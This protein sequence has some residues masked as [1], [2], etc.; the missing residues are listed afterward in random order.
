[1]SSKFS[2]R[3]ALSVLSGFLLFA[4]FP[5]LNWHWFVWVATLPLLL[6]LVCERSL[7]RA[8]LLGYISGFIFLGGSCYWFVYVMR[9][10]GGMGWLL[11]IGVLVLFLIVFSVFFGAFGLVEGFIAQRS[12]EFALLAAPFLWVAMEVARTYL[13]TGFPWNLLGY[14]V[15]DG[16]LRQIASVTAVYG[17]SFLAVSISAL[18]AWWL[19][20][21]RNPFRAMG[22]AT[23]IVG[24]FV[25]N[26]LVSP[27]PMF[28]EHGSYAFLV[29]P[30][31]PLDETKLE[32]WIPWKNPKN[33]NDLVAATDRVA[34]Q[35]TA[36]AVS[37]TPPD[38]SSSSERPFTPAL[39]VWPENPAPFY[40]DRD[41]VFREALE[42]VA[43]HTGDYTIS[44]TTLFDANGRPRNS[45]VVLDPSG[46]LILAYDKIHLV[47]FGEYVPW[48]A[49]PKLVGKITFE[50]GDF[51]PGTEYKVAQTPQGGIGVFICYESI[52]PQLVR[53]LTDRG[54]GVLVNISDD[55]WF[56]SSS[57]GE[58]HLEM[59]RLR[60]IENHRYLLRATNDG[61][62]AIIDP[63][64]E[65]VSSMPRNQPGV[66][67]GRFGYITGTTFYTRHGDVF[68][69]TCV[70]I[71]AIL[72][73]VVEVQKK[74]VRGEVAS[75]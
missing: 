56:G 18:A 4:S 63:H 65:I 27:V 2:L 35:G 41:Q 22:F 26:L 14:A 46:N 44:G 16:G 24:L 33:L 25:V 67:T 51:A 15:D 52:F 74:R 10:Y 9:R 72:L 57:A 71:T 12:P 11:A 55:G 37:A 50:A 8:F 66:L 30:N 7:R 61:I 53:K 23:A 54:A 32:E 28:P 49:F 69:W 40:F 60:A 70:A 42:S 13:I 29:Q 48:W 68:A 75:G 59:A 38:C 21:A 64:G 20:D 1:M 6:A 31:I 36:F 39:V 17:L 19:F 43:K 5:F 73:L 47:P 58:Q 3:L 34:C 62:T 45:A